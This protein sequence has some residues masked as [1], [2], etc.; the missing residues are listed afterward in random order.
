MFR[1]AFVLILGTLSLSCGGPE[2]N[3]ALV[4]TIKPLD[5]IVSQILPEQLKAVTL[6]KAGNSVHDYSMT[7]DD[8]KN[9]SRAKA[10]IK[11]GWHLDDWLGKEA[12]GGAAFIFSEKISP[13]NIGDDLKQGADPHFWISPKR[14]INGLPA[15]TEFLIAHFPEHAD[16]ISNNSKQFHKELLLIHEKYLAAFALRTKTEFFAYHPA[17]RYL[18]EDYGMKLLGHMHSAHSDSISSKRM[19]EIVDILSNSP[20]PVFIGEIGIDSGAIENIRSQ[21]PQ[22]R[23]IY[24]DPI[25]YFSEAMSYSD[26]SLYNIEI[27]NESI[28]R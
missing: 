14:V 28:T 1:Y 24:L 26:L 27:I 13:V 25:G 3:I 10:L 9:L 5:L 11:V 19:K 8:K 17:W 20:N 22:M 16:Q 7:I 4:S 23:I 15:L 18:S 12:S 2:Q 6:V 21:I